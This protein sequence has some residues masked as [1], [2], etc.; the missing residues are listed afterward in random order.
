MLNDVILVVDD[1]QE[2]IRTV[3]HFLNSKDFRLLIA[4]S[5][6]QALELLESVQPNLILLDVIMPPGI[7]GFEVCRILKSQRKTQHIP[8]IF[9]TALTDSV[10]KVRGFELGAADYVT[11]PIQHSE[12][13]ARINTH[14]KIHGL[15]QQL[16]ARGRQLEK[17]NDELETFSYAISHSLRSPLGVVKLNLQDI[18]EEIFDDDNLRKLRLAIGANDKMTQIIDSLLIFARVVNHKAYEKQPLDMGVLIANVLQQRLSP[19]FR[20]YQGKIT[21]HSKVDD[22]PIVLGYAPWV[23]EIWANYLSNG[24]KYGGRPPHLELGADLQDDR[25]VRFWVR[26]NGEGLEKDLINQLFKPFVR[27]HRDRAEGQGLGLSI[28]QKIVERLDGEV[29]VESSR[30]EGCL[31]YF[32]LPHTNRKIFP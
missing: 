4:N 29:G 8:V 12:T 25:T 6:Q 22:W 15:Q 10:S 3:Y 1:I 18:P 5:G 2:S 27:L 13:L 26:D 16:Q 31:F 30:G 14:L 17:R 24:L 9:M 20:K 19:L 11:K 21:Y 7:S 23:E 32:T 28:V